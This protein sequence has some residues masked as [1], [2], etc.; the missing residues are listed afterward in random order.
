VWDG[1][2]T[3]FHP[4]QVLSQWKPI[5]LYSRGAWQNRGLWPDVVRVNS[6]EK[7]V[8][9]WQ[10]PLEEA[11][12]LVRYF[13]Q[14]GDLVVDP[15]GGGFTTAE[16]C[17]R[18]SRKC[19]SCDIVPEYVAKGQERLEKARARLA[20]KPG[21]APLPGSG[22]LEILNGEQSR[23]PCMEGTLIERSKRHSEQAAPANPEDLKER[24]R[25]DRE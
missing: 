19:V 3:I 10:Q 14:P 17:L 7:D 15:C 13:S 6:K 20:T 12:R 9:D 25:D 8:H 1:D 18:H 23:A 21:G 24:K 11:E 4:R 5:L 22:T 16:A 2:A